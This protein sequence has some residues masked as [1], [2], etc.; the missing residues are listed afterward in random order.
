MIFKII[1]ADPYKTLST[2]KDQSVKDGP[3][4]CL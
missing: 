1:R 2:K 4:F 3:S